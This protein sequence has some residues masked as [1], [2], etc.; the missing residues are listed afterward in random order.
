MVNA[1]QKVV[2]KEKR[3]LKERRDKNLIILGILEADCEN[4]RAVVEKLLQE[5]S[6]KK[7]INFDKIFDLSN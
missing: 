2:R 6:I 3:D 7:T 5:C 4:I 1:A